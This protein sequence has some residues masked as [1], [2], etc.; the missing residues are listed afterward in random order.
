[1]TAQDS[2]NTLFANFCE[3]H[4]RL[5][6][7]QQS[8]TAD[9]AEIARAWGDY[10]VTYCHV[11]V[12]NNDSDEYRELLEETA[13]KITRIAKAQS[14]FYNDIN[15]EY[16]RKI[17]RLDELDEKLDRLSRSMDRHLDKL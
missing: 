12:G 4:H 3:L 7:M 5:M 11:R 1:M 16:A 9:P 17:E 2:S 6:E 15:D 10:V 14:A 13:L 8:E